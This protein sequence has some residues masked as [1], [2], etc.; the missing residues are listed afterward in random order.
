M[1]KIISPSFP[2][3]KPPSLNNH[4][5]AL[6]PQPASVHQFDHQHISEHVD[7]GLDDVQFGAVHIMPLHRHLA[8]FDLKDIAQH[9]QLDVE[10]PALD[11]QGLEQDFGGVCGEEFEAALGVFGFDAA[12]DGLDEPEYG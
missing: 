4:T 11:M 1:S 5:V 6:F 10:C 3:K 8:G 12:D 7:G 2:N 9:E